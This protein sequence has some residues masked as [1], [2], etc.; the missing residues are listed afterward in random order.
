MDIKELLDKA[1][2]EY[3]SITIEAN[4]THRCVHINAENF[5]PGRKYRKMSTD[6]PW[7]KLNKVDVAINEILE[8]ILE[9]VDE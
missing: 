3:I 6:V 7:K 5:A 1:L 2:A 8:R 4:A 9:E